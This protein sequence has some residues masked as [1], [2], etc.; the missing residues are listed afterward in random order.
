MR[1]DVHE[2]PFEEW[3]A[4]AVALLS[5]IASIEVYLSISTTKSGE[6]AGAVFDETKW[7][8]SPTRELIQ[9]VYSQCGELSNSK[10]TRMNLNVQ[11]ERT[12]GHSRHFGTLSAEDSLRGVV[13]PLP[14]ASQRFGVS[15]R[16][17]DSCIYEM[18]LI[19]AFHNPMM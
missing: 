17:T 2:G 11:A 12:L 9:L 6:M 16:S 1:I 18:C 7:L 13:T 19:H 8:A 5:Q 4:L 3:F 15:I 10:K 14:L